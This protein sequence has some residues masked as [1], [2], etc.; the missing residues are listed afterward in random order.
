MHVTRVYW[1]MNDIPFLLYAVLCMSGSVR[2]DNGILIRKVHVLCVR[3]CIHSQ[4]IV[5]YVNYVCTNGTPTYL[6]GF[7]VR[8]CHA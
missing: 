5:E 1:V 4:C 8:V 3:Y 2:K 7:I 6:I